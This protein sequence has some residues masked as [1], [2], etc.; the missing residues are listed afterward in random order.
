[1]RVEWLAVV[2]LSFCCSVN[3]PAREKHDIPSA[4]MLEFLGTYETAD[5]KGFDPMVLQGRPHKKKETMKT[6]SRSVKA[7]QGKTNIKGTR[8]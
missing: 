7:K 8:L 6:K 3:A 4:D 5:K 1:M 2:A